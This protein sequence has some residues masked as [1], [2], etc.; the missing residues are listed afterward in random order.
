MAGMRPAHGTPGA[1]VQT[2]QRHLA[3]LRAGSETIE[4]GADVGH[5]EG[6][7]DHR[8]HQAAAEHVEQLAEFA[9]AAAG[10]AV[11]LELADE[12]ALQIGGRIGRPSSRRR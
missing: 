9:D 10:R 12:D 8:L 11:D 6:R 7:V 3:E 4:S 5:R 1:S 2:D